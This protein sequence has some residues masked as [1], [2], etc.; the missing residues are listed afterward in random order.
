ML[1]GFY[2]P[3]ET[4]TYAKLEK[5]QFECETLPFLGYIVS[6]SGFQMDPE[7]VAAI[8]NWP[9]PSGLK[10]LQRFLGFANFYRHFI[11]HYSQKVAPLT[12]LTR[13]GVNA[14]DWPTTA[15]NAF[16]ELKQAFLAA[17][18]LRHQDP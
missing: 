12:A 3:L 17:P 4:I 15:S 18:C 14:H 6:S 16:E 13:K 2:K 10:A 11:P 8:I 1:S 9:R 7:K 5:C